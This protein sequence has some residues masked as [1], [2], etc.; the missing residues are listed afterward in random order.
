[1]HNNRWR[2][3]LFAVCLVCTTS[4][5]SQAAQATIA[6]AANFTQ[7]AKQL[8]TAFEND[9]EHS[10]KM[11]YGSTGK[12]F[13]QI[14]HGAP[15]DVFLAA[16]TLRPT[17]LLD[18]KLAVAGS[19]TRY[20][21]GKLVLYASD[22]TRQ[23]NQDTLKPPTT[24]RRLAIANPKT[25]PYGAA[26]KSVLDK[27]GISTEGELKLI[28]GDSIAQT[29]QFSFTGNVDAGF[30]ALAQVIQQPKANYWLVP[31][32]LYPALTQDA[33]LLVR[34]EKNPAAVAFLTFLQSAQAHEIITQLGYQIP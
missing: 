24:V 28:Q 17:W 14:S 11:S 7:A 23:L 22:T 19:R 30:I 2:W 29:Y 12:L 31:Q 18:R 26:A 4:Q 33:V 21:Q 20:A 13:T 8:Q 5:S 27:L 1:M 32:S 9:S 16:D 34:G 3:F 10:L 25:A 6:V 15:Y